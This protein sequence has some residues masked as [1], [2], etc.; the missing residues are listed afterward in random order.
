MCV[1]L[2]GEK[3]THTKK[4]E[5]LLAASKEK[6]PEVGTET[7]KYMLALTSGNKEGNRK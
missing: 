7:S 1:R 6:V 3:H 4:T 2:L 5:A